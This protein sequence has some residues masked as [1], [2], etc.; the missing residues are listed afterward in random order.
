[1]SVLFV[2]WLLALLPSVSEEKPLEVLDR[3]IKAVGGEQHLRKLANSQYR[4]EVTSFV[5]G[6]RQPAWQE[7][8]LIRLP[9]CIKHEVTDRKQ[10]ATYVLHGTHGWVQFDGQ[11]ETMGPREIAARREDLHCIKIQYLLEAKEPRYRLR[12]LPDKRV[13]GTLSAGILVSGDGVPDVSLYFDKGSG[14]LVKSEM[15]IRDKAMGHSVFREIFLPPKGYENIDGLKYPMLS[16]IYNDYSKSQEIKV[17]EIK[18][19]ETIRES[20]FLRPG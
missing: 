17:K 9:D 3:A 14:L 20:E 6:E 2:S 15:R 8:S 16:I 4:S 7:K 10:S 19:L 18:F 13:E 5:A 12:M 11:T 1:M